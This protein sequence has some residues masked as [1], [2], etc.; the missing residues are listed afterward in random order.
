[1][2]AVSAAEVGAKLE[3]AGVAQGARE[4]AALAEFLNLLAQWNRTYN[5][6]GIR[7][8]DEL[9]SRHL[10]ESL[11][12]APLLE[13]IR[14]ADIGTGAGLPGI[15]LAIVASD[16]QFTLIESRAKRVRFLRHAIATLGLENAVVAH[17]RAEDLPAGPA[18]D[19]VL[20]RAVAR[21]EALV[22]IARPL[23]TT[24]SILIVLT[25][26]ELAQR[27]EGVAADF[28]A[29]LAQTRAKKLKSAIV[30]LERVAAR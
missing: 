27:F 15:P 13:G 26:A 25:S 20:A 9:I 7:T 23:M 3:L 10:V 18:F 5:L 29:A 21:P 8:A 2:K 30:V 22:E 28:A 4:T 19:T 6:T 24:G 1:M 11:A 12:L 16:R 14:V 17:S